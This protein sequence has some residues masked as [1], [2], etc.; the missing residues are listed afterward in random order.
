MDFKQSTLSKYWIEHKTTFAEY[1]CFHLHK[2]PESP[3]RLL[4]ASVLSTV[5]FSAGEKIKA[6]LRRECT[7]FSEG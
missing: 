7:F 1:P 6:Y 2:I 4:L 5:K 3:L